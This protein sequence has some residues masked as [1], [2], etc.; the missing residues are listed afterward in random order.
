M[1]ARMTLT[2]AAILGTAV[3]LH[4]L[5]HGSLTSDLILTLQYVAL[6]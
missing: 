4:C 5:D 1:A 6:S 2:L 3:P